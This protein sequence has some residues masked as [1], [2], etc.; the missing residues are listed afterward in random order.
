MLTCTGAWRVGL[1]AAIVLGLFI[2]APMMNKLDLSL[3][4]YDTVIRVLARSQFGGGQARKKSAVRRAPRPD[5]RR[6][7]TA[8]VSVRQDWKIISMAV[9]GRTNASDSV[10]GDMPTR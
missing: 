1:T 4:A 6:G 8:T 7:P 3:G 5:V 10:T 9:N 2:F